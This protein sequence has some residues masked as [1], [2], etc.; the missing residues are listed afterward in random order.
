MDKNKDKI[1]KKEIILQKLEDAY[2]K[3]YA[4]LGKNGEKENFIKTIN[5][6]LKP[7]K[8]LSTLRAY[9][10]DPSRLIDNEEM[11]IMFYGMLIPALKEK[12][13]SIAEPFD[14]AIEE[15]ETLLISY[16]NEQ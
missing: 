14:T 8:S 2:K 16:K 13:D 3:Y 1:S 10:P 7:E 6:L 15:L 12:R 11:K 4:L 5:S 9:A